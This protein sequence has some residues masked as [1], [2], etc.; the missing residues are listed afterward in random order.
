MLHHYR[1]S[2]LMELFSRFSPM[3]MDDG[4]MIKDGHFPSSIY[5]ERMDAWVALDRQMEK[6]VTPDIVGREELRSHWADCLIGRDE[7]ID[8]AGF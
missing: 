4:V 6:T 3:Q 5:I 8:F 1:Q 7:V 2:E